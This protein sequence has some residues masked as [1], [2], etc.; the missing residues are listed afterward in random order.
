MADRSDGTA[1]AGAPGG[2]QRPDLMRR[3]LLLGVPLGAVGLLAATRP[4]QVTAA[5]R[6]PAGVAGGGGDGTR[7]LVF[8]IQRGAADG[9]M[10]VI[11]T[12]DPALSQARRDMAAAPTPRSKGGAGAK[13]G[14]DFALHPALGTLG[15]LAA[16]GEATIIHA[17]GLAYR[18]RSHFDSQN[19]LETGGR[20]PYAVRDG[21]MNR[22]VGMLADAARG[23]A[24]GAS[25]VPRALAYAE[26]L[27]QVL[28]GDRPAT[29]FAPARLAGHDVEY[30][31]RIG[32]MY[33]GDAALSALM[34]TAR[35]TRAAAAGTG[36]PA[37]DAAATGTNVARLMSGPDG[38]Q[39]V[40]I[41]AEGWDTH[42]AQGAR[43]ATRLA[44][45]D[46]MLSGLKSGLGAAW[47][48]TLV[49]IATE[50]GR[51]VAVNGSGGT[52]HGTASAMMLAGGAVRGGRGVGTVVADWPGLA[53]GQLFE[54]RDLR[55]TRSL[56]AVIAS[57]VAGQFGLDPARTLT[58]LFPGA[59]GARMEAGW[60]VA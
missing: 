22:L 14:A 6:T 9:V 47:A 49:V 37:A 1:A 31:D 40:A 44:G 50:F 33:E 38:A 59:A 25:T 3:A 35:A 39:I 32:R 53:P 10:S 36:D 5:L 13:L 60:V 55:P 43:L 16:G 12:S 18:D 58:T 45:L 28:R 46:A 30:L 17:V 4:F 29:S 21:W 42:Q 23:G 7:R 15:A 2:A 57:A 19:I 41:E 8:I 56:E 48:T 20:T 54:G 34:A 26:T 27:P 24:A 52:D 11:P 51:T